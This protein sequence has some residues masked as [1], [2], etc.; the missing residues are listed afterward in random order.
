MRSLV[1]VHEKIASQDE[2][3]FN[4]RE[5]LLKVAEEEDAAGRIMAR[6]FADELQKLADGAGIMGPAPQVNINPAQMA[7]AAAN[8]ARATAPGQGGGM[9]V[10][11]QRPQAP[12]PPT[13][14]AMR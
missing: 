1:D 14:T 10:Q 7:Q 4:E 3:Y 2:V 12:K 13:A 8:K 11:G 5:E 6:G 9:T